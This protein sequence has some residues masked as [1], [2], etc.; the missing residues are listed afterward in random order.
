M[1]DGVSIVTEPQNFWT[2]TIQFDIV[3]IQWPEEL[4]DW[5]VLNEG[6]II[7]L[8]ERLNFWKQQGAKI[9]ATLHNAKPH[10]DKGFGEELYNLVYTQADCIVHL[11][12]YSL[13]LYPN[14]NNVVIPHPNYNALVKNY[15]PQKSDKIRFLSFGTIR[16][17]EEEELLINAFKMAQIPNSQITIHRS[18]IATKPYFSRRDYFKEKKFKKSIKLYEKD[19]IFLSP[20]KVENADFDTIFGSTDI[21]VIPRI[22]SLNSGVIFMGFTYGKVVVGPNIGNIQ[23]FLKINDNPVYDAGNTS[24]L[25]NA[26]KQAVGLNEVGHKNK[27]YSD[28]HFDAKK[29]AQKHIEL[30]NSLKR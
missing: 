13:S 20:K 21:V 16:S 7:K 5:K 1:I 29:V 9:V 18:L 24:S 10:K 30:Y 19:N 26:M 8:R 28:L 6:D 14:Q 15:Q 4:F 2:S 3:H 27:M 17:I 22:N 25:A 11:G 12:N 23:E